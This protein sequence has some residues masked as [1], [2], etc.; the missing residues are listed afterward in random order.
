MIMTAYSTTKSGYCG[1][2]AAA[3]TFA[4]NEKIMDTALGVVS[5][6]ISLEIPVI[7]P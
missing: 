5:I 7:Y 1:Y 4:P 6:A 2:T 3:C